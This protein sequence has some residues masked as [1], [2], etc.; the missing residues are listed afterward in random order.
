MTIK[1][2]EWITNPRI[3]EIN[4]WPWLGFLSETFNSPIT[5]KNIPNKVFKKDIRHFDAV[6]L[7]G[8]WERSPASKKIALEHPDLLKEYHKALYDF[9]DEDVVGSP[10]SIYYYHV[11][12]HI[13]GVDG[14]K[15]VRKRLSEQDIR[16]I[17]DYVPNHVSIDSLWT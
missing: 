3:L 1:H 4:T 15:E 14:I 13:G 7:M 2:T 9:R 5:L 8:V 17:L 16:L 12:N 10:Y 6:W 11:D